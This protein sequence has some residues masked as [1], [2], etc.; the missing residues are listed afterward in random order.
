MNQF[1]SHS[2]LSNA[3]LLSEHCDLLWILVVSCILEPVQ[4]FCNKN[5]VKMETK[6]FT[7]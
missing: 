1:P 5:R 3:G 4:G 2:L 7:S 6:L